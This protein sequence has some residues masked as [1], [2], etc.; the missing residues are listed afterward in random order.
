MDQE[1]RQLSGDDRRVSFAARPLIAFVRMY[2][3]VG[4]PFFG[5][6]CRFHPTCSEYAAEALQTHGALRGT[7]LALRRVLRCHPLG[8]AGYDPVPP[9]RRR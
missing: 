3:A 6:H 9:P 7:F 2:Q 1:S 5:G 4:R 8:G